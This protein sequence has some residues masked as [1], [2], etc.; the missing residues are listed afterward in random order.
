MD[1]NFVPFYHCFSFLFSPLRSKVCTKNYFAPKWTRCMALDNHCLPRNTSYLEV[2]SFT[3][4]TNRIF[5]RSNS[6]NSRAFAKFWC[7]ESLSA[8]RGRVKILWTLPNV[9]KFYISNQMSN[10]FV[11]YAILYASCSC[12][13]KV[14]WCSSVI[15][16]LWSQNS[17]V[18]WV[19]A[20]VGPQHLSVMTMGRGLG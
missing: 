9:W 4:S 8:L 15:L 16:R 19:R 13:L 14:L 18:E 11:R 17:Q 6:V 10:N 7:L 1:S 12:L 3:F 2:F 5:K 20:P